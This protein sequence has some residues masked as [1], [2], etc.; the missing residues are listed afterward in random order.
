ML[1]TFDIDDTIRLHGSSQPSEPPAK[2]WLAR[3]LYREPLRPGFRLLCHDLRTLGWRIGIYTTSSRSSGYIRRWM[4][5]YGLTPD[6]IV[7]A[8]I[9][10]AAVAGRH[11]QGRPPSKHPGL[12]GADLH[13]DDSEGVAMEATRFGFHALIIDPEDLK[14]GDTILEAVRSFAPGPGSLTDSPSASGTAE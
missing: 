13:I 10:E 7:N 8:A 12:F 14:W 9:H 6:L 4:R 3:L 5:C 1:I 2:A 11:G